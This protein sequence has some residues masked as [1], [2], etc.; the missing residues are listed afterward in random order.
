M[1]IA[2][3]S[4]AVVMLAVAVTAFV[5][6]WGG[7]ET[8]S[9]A[10]DRKGPSECIANTCTLVLADL[11]LMAPEVTIDRIA[12]LLAERVAGMEP[13]TYM[14]HE[15]GVDGTVGPSSRLYLTFMKTTELVTV[16]VGDERSQI[17]TT[18]T[19]RIPMPVGH[20]SHGCPIREMLAE[21]RRRHPQSERVTATLSLADGPK[22]NVHE[23]KAGGGMAW[24]LTLAEDCA[25]L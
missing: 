23:T 16:V 24:H 3:T 2:A 9:S 19:A 6:A 14:L 21:V 5:V 25:P 13:T 1:A 12:A 17:T 11:D 18:P 7:P 10:P 20:L 15:V 8:S 22:W 4:A